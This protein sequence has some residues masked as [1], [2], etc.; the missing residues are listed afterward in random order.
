MNSQH[1]NNHYRFTEQGKQRNKSIFERGGY[2]KASW[3]RK[4][5]EKVFHGLK[6]LHGFRTKLALEDLLSF[7]GL[8]KKKN[9]NS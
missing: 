6:F 7:F 3:K 8:K 4:M 9:S 2:L 5:G 1:Y